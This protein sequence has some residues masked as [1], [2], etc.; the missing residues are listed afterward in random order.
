MMSEI[1][2]TA[3]RQ[4]QSV[5]GLNQLIRSQPPSMIARSLTSVYIYK[6]M[7]CDSAVS[8]DTTL[9]CLIRIHRC[10]ICMSW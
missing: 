2:V 9:E 3:G 4:A 5:I 7:S 8:P 6:Q 10:G 1:R